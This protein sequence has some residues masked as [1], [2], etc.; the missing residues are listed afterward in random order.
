MKSFVPQTSVYALE[1]QLSV[2]TEPGQH[3]QLM[4]ELETVQCRSH[5]VLVEWEQTGIQAFGQNI[6]S[7][8]LHSSKA[9]GDWKIACFRN[10]CL[11]SEMMACHRESCG[12]R[13]HTDWKETCFRGNLLDEKLALVRRSRESRA[14]EQAAKEPIWIHR[15]P[16]LRIGWREAMG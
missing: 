16:R 2:D 3:W 12:L 6:S 4:N 9:Q 11:M 5:E 10:Y 13:A 7:R 15:L 8:K 1:H 14:A